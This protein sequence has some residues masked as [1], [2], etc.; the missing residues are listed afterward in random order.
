MTDRSAAVMWKDTIRD[1]LEEAEPD[2][3]GGDVYHPAM[4]VEG[5]C[6]GFSDHELAM[7]GTAGFAF[8]QSGFRIL[9]HVHAERIEGA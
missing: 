2:H 5:E 4:Y 6:T 1:A 7:A 8:E 3:P 9:V